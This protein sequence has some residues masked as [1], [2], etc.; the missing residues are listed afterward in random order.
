MKKFTKLLGIVLIIA[1]VMSMGISSA[2]ATSITI[3]S[4][5]DPDETATDK[6][7]YNWYKI[8]DATIEDAS[9]ITV[10]KTT[11]ESTAATTGANVPK[12][13]YYVDSQAK[14]TAISGT[15]LFT[16]TADQ[17][18]DPVAKWYVALTDETTSADDIVAAFSA[19]TFDLSLFDTDTFAQTTVGGSATADNLDPGY[20]YITST[21]G[22]K[23][24]V[25]T[26]ADIE[27]NTKNQYPPVEKKFDDVASGDTADAS[28]QIGDEVEYVLTVSVPDSANDSIVLTDT[29]TVGLTFKEITA[30]TADGADLTEGTAVEA[31]TATT[32]TQVTGGDYFASS[33]TTTADGS[34]FTIT[35]GEAVVSANKGKDIVVKYTA[36]LNENAVVS[37]SADGNG[38][39]NTVVLDYGNNY[40]SVPKKVE[41]DTQKFTFDKVDG[42]SSGTKLPG[43]V[44][45]LRRDGTALP[46][47][48]VAAGETYRIA[49]DAEIAD[50]SVTK[51]TSM[52]T[53]GK[54]ITVNGVDG[55]IT[56]QLV[57]TQAPTGYN[58]PSNPSTDVK[59]N[60]DNTLEITIENNK[61]SVLPS[62]GGIGTT[63]FYVV[64]SILVVAAGVL[65]ITKKR[66]SREG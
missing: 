46:L 11:G 58:M 24:A 56:Y 48:E 8:F 21:L 54:V 37:T 14:A 22:D 32:K 4:T 6:T 5:A 38:N 2:F 40:T 55:D 62:T 19:A 41:T 42:S 26:L 27:I 52:T 53:T 7:V 45:E 43:A 44:F 20:Y 39:I 16:V 10:D 49:T 36:I 63:I 50:D 57:E 12:V 17:S 35:F 28:A 13:S 34:S 51:V 66:M 25:Q 65:L 15:G 60:T 31:A 33:V 1:L 23:I 59:A 61:G 30:V 18:T 9:L 3:N 29:M 47:I 64:G